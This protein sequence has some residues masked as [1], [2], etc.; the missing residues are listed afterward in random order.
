MRA[1]EACPFRVLIHGDTENVQCRACSDGLVIDHTLPIRACEDCVKYERVPNPFIEEVRR[2]IRAA[3][4]CEPHVPDGP[5]KIYRI[6]VEEAAAGIA[7]TT[8]LRHVIERS[9]TRGHQ[10]AAKAMQLVCDQLG[11]DRDA[12]AAIVQ[13][14]GVA[15]EPIDEVLAAAREHGLS[16][17]D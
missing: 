16:R 3:R 10:T 12:L 1:V 6:S 7:G 8:L 2:H 5:D 9:V 4:V 11:G 17:Q 14:A 13:A 15:G